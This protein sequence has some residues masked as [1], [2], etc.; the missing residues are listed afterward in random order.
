MMF[1]T[2]SIML[3]P[4]LLTGS[5]V[6]NSIGFPSLIRPLP[7]TRSSGRISV[8]IPITLSYSKRSGSCIPM[9]LVK[10]WRMRP[11]ISPELLQ[12]KIM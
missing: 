5:A 1:L 11:R 4:V 9:P 10:P 7:L 6:W 8:R 12:L 3:P 2:V